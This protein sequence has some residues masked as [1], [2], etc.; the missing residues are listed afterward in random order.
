MAT[1]GH[2]NTVDSE[3]LNYDCCDGDC[4]EEVLGTEAIA[5]CDTPPVRQLTEHDL[6]LVASM[7]Y[8]APDT[9]D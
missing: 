4:G 6:D 3:P 5:G 9:V 1:L 2:S 8:S 7:D